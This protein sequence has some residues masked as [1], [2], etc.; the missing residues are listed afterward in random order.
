MKNN[1]YLQDLKTLE[2]LCQTAMNLSITTSGRMAS[3]WREEY[4]SHIFAKICVTVIAILKLLPK[5]TFYVA[6]ENMEIWDISSVCTLA[7]SLIDSYNAF[8]YL[9]IEKVDRD[10]LE[11]R[12][13]L[14]HLHSECERLEM[15][16]LIKST[17]SKVEELRQNIEN[18]RKKLKNNKFYQKLNLK[19]QKV[20]SSGDKGIFLTNREI[21][22]KAGINPDYY[23]A[24]YKYLSNYVHTY[25]FS[26]SQIAIFN[27][28][29]PQSLQLF[30][31]I[32]GYCTA[33]LCLSLRDFLK[34]VPDQSKNVPSDV[35]N[36]VDI[37]EGIVKF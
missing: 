5:S 12:F 26:I 8:H 27:A 10:E 1:H 13:S 11:F 32:V 20:Y 4:G 15:L 35:M 37:W 6:K 14:W 17:S 9:I 28:K 36:T 34:I 19:E 33:Y 7:R 3:S 25:S 22:K 31:P 2:T 29:D 21:S 30:E 18:L 23:K 24:V 16:E